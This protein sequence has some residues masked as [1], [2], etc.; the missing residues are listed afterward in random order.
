MEIDVNF[1]IF[2]LF[3]DNSSEDSHNLWVKFKNLY[4][5]ILNFQKLLRN[6]IKKST[7]TQKYQQ[8]KKNINDEKQRMKN[9]VQLFN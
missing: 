4:E 6:S 1:G 9:S 8:K 3:I 2:K 5:K 7:K